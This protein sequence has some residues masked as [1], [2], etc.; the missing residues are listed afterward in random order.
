LV[1]QQ[2]HHGDVAFAGG[3]MQRRPAWAIDFCALCDQQLRDVDLVVN[4]GQHQRRLAL[5]VV[6]IDACAGVM[7]QQLGGFC[8]VR[9]NGDD[10][11]GCEVFARAVGVKTDSNQAADCG[12]IVELDGTKKSI[13]RTSFRRRKSNENI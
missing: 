12:V 7:E 1:E 11:G 6:D 4:G 3:V 8:G 9:L 13:K 5:G 2:T 10:Q